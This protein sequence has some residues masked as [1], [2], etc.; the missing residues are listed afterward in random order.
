MIPDLS[1][2]LYLAVFGL[3]CGALRQ[4]VNDN[5]KL[6][7]N[8]GV[9]VPR[10]KMFDASP[11]RAV[12]PAQPA[13]WAYPPRQQQEQAPVQLQGNVVIGLDPRLKIMS[14]DSNILGV[15][16]GSKPVTGRAVGRP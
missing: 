4:V 8:G 14:A 16:I 15:N 11:K 3:I 9:R 2:I 7:A 5:L 13:A 12:L 6:P 10:S 1:A